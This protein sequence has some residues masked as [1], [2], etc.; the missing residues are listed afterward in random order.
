MLFELE[1]N[2]T[3]DTEYGQGIICFIANCCKQNIRFPAGL[4]H[5]NIKTLLLAYTTFGILNI[6]C[7]A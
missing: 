7:F 3:S 1:S 5:I 2:S 6:L 4:L